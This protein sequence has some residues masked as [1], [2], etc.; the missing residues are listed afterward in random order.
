MILEIALG[1]LPMRRG[2]NSSLNIKAR[3]IIIGHKGW[4]CRKVADFGIARGEVNSG[5]I[6]YSGTM[7]GSGP[8]CISEQARGELTQRDSD[9][10]SLGC[11]MYEMVTESRVAFDADSPVTVALKHVS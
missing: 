5:T 9:L 6:T 7:V 8:L 4:Y 11:V 1:P 10:Y 3:T 2:L